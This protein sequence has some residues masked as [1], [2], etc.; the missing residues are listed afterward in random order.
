MRISRKG[1]ADIKSLKI[2]T[3]ARD[4]NLEKKHRLRGEKKGTF[5]EVRTS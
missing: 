5:S 4:K 1:Y 3:K 2:T